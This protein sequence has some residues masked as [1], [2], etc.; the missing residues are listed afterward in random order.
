MGIFTWTASVERKMIEAFLLGR[1]GF[2]PTY[3]WLEKVDGDFIIGFDKT[4]LNFSFKDGFLK[5]VEAI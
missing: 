4:T 3:D 5:S 2:V 1:F